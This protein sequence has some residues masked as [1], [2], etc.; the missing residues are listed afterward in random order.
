MSPAKSLTRD[1]ILD[2]FNRHAARLRELGVVRLGLFGSSVRGEAG[3]DS[4]IDV[5]VT[6]VD[7]RYST[8]C[9]VLFYLEDLFNRKID[10]VPEGSIRPE[11]RPHI[12]SEAAYAE[13]V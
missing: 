3:P 7:H 5:L 9:R 11:L 12:L 6:L 2:L 8:Y 10:L 13:R 1:Q 4:D